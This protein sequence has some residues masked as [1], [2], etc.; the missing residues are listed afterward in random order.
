MA[1]KRGDYSTLCEVRVGLAAYYVYLNVLDY[2]GS[3]RTSKNGSAVG[4]AVCVY[5][6]ILYNRAFADKTYQTFR[7]NGTRYGMTRSVERSAE[8]VKPVY[9]L[10]ILVV[11]VIEFRFGIA[12]IGLQFIISVSRVLCVVGF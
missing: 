3:Y 6:E 11:A 12:D 1:H 7:H 5:G 4:V 9:V 2:G 10:P 8:T